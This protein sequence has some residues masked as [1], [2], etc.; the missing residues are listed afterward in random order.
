[1]SFQIKD[2]A[3]E[4]LRYLAEEALDGVD[5]GEEPQP[6]KYLELVF[7]AE[8]VELKGFVGEI[9]VCTECCVET[10]I[11]EY[12]CCLLYTSPSPRDRQKSRM[13]SSA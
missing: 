10:Y 7:G 5:Y 2:P 9:K 11:P 4:E 3:A 1:M 13:P 12:Y 8:I 6:E